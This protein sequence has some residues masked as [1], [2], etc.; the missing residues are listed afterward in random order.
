[1]NALRAACALAL[2]ATAGW[3]GTLEMYTGARQIADRPTQL[4]NYRLPVA[5]YDGETVPSIN[6][7]GRITRESWRIEGG[8]ITSLQLLAPLRAQLR[9]QGFTVVFECEAQVC[10]GFDF[11]FGT[12][13][14]PAPDMHVDIRDYRFLAARRGTAEAVG[15][16]VSRGRSANY[17]QVIAVAPA[18]AATGAAAA[19]PARGAVDPAQ[20]PAVGNQPALRGGDGDV[21][22]EADAG[23]G[24]APGD[25]ERARRVM[26]ETLLT[27]GH[28]VLGGLD[29]ETG[30]N[31]LAS[32]QLPDLDI[33]ADILRSRPDL[34]VALVGHTDSVG[35]L[36]ANIALSRSRAEAVRDRLVGDYGLP[37]TQ[38]G[39]E[40]M[41]YLAPIA[42]NLTPVGRDLNR[43]VEVIVL[44]VAE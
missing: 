14:I 6:L 35:S 29:F 21:P 26:Q 4:G 10:G 30:S 5:A 36:E 7:E 15:I 8:G 40:G 18:P 23:T 38:I 42:S 16:L 44:S 25:P 11:R 27:R 9:A 39:A 32:G 24:D 1:M 28:V 19:P 43:R 12:E 37:S 3:G 34:R 22:A 17:V 20:T 31:A 2:A 13:V 41:G 33:L